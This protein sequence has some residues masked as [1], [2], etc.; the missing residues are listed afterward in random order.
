MSD[1]ISFESKQMLSDFISF[2]SKQMLSDFISS[3]NKS[4]M[5]NKA[6]NVAIISKCSIL[7]IMHVNQFLLVTRIR[8]ILRNGSTGTGLRI[9][10]SVEALFRS[11]LCFNKIMIR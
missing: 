11:R 4:A 8:D 9:S 3:E 7:L 1:F 5:V 6:K 10:P 2:E